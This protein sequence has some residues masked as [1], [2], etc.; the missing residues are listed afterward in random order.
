MLMG[1][2]LH[3]DISFDNYLQWIFQGKQDT[4]ERRARYA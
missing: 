1:W 3:R 2:A 4:P